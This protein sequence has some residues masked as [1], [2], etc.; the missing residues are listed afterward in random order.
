M[1]TI[2][3][4]AYFLNNGYFSRSVWLHTVEILSANQ[5]FVIVFSCTISLPLLSFPSQRRCLMGHTWRQWNSDRQDGGHRH[6]KSC[7]AFSR[8]QPLADGMQ[9]HIKWHF[10]PESMPKSP[11]WKY[12]KERGCSSTA[13]SRRQTDFDN[14]AAAN[15]ETITIY[16]AHH[17]PVA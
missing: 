3:K 1:P 15:M 6:R 12:C 11:R 9:L 14:V 7:T 13:A 10:R 5:C 4:L 16:S 8:H 17:S 2:L